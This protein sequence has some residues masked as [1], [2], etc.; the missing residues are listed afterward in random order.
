MLRKLILSEAVFSYVPTG[1]YAGDAFEVSDEAIGITILPGWHTGNPQSYAFATWHFRDSTGSTA[2]ASKVWACLARLTERSLGGLSDGGCLMMGVCN[3]QDLRTA[4]WIHGVGV[5]AANGSRNYRIYDIENGIAQSPKDVVNSNNIGRQIEVVLG[6]SGLRQASPATAVTPVDG[7][8]AD[9][10]L[11]TD[12]VG[13]LER[14]RSV[15][16]PN[17]TGDLYIFAALGVANNDSPASRLLRTE[18]LVQDVVPDDVPSYVVD[19][20]SWA[21]GYSQPILCLGDSITYGLSGE[22]RAAGGYRRS[23]ESLL[24]AR[25]PGTAYQC[26]YPMIGSVHFPT[27]ASFISSANLHSEGHSG[28]TSADIVAGL[29]GWSA[30]WV[31]S[32]KYVLLH[33]GT[34]DISTNVPNATTVANINTIVTWFATHYPA[35]SVYVAQIIPRKDASASKVAPLNAAIVAGVAGATII[36]LNTGFP[37]GGISPDNIHPNYVGYAWMANQ[38]EPVIP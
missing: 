22:P 8:N 11:G 38:W 19:S 33:I 21:D 32:P 9:D 37:N 24:W 3:D 13:K 17:G 6:R 31:Y 30:S 15:G 34:N 36:D 16:W 35:A 10:T 18:V 28:Y 20:I 25:T 23:L 26:K 7:N 29:S 14:T 2:P 27:D 12:T 1:K 5:Y 4:T